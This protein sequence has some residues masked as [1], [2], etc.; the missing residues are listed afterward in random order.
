MTRIFMGNLKL[1][2]PELLAGIVL[3]TSCSVLGK[4]SLHGLSSGN[5]K[6][7]SGKKA[8]MVYVDITEE[9]IDVYNQ[10][11][12]KIDENVYLSIPLQNPDT[13]A[14]NPLKLQKQALDIDIT[15]ILFKYRP[16]VYGLPHQLTTD[17][18][19][20][21]YAGWRHDHYKITSH[22]NLLDKRYLKFSDFGYDFGIFAGPGATSITPFTTNNRTEH[23]YSGMIIQTGIAGFLESNI[24]SFG[25]AVG[26][27]YLMGSDR[28][29]WIYN[30]KP[31]IGF[32]VG[33]AFN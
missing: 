31:W 5:Y 33:V 7:D 11:E 29:I 1:I 10:H 16:S 19:F 23:E 20:S 9:K 3:L 28:K 22:K 21:L 14:I 24:A 15:T 32:I 4:A 6:L 26:R 30:H 12:N 25:V 27:D 18:N 13:L 17:L 2:V 8:K